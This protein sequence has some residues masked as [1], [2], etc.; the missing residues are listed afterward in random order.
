MRPRSVS[1]RGRSPSWGKRRRR[2]CRAAGIAPHREDGLGPVLQVQHP[3]RGDRSDHRRKRR[4]Q[5]D[6][7][8]ALP[9][10]GR[11]G[12]DLLAAQERIL[13]T[14]ARGI[15]GTPGLSPLERILAIF[16]LLE[17]S[18]CAPSFRSC[19]FVNGMAELGP[20]VHSPKVQETIAAYFAG[21]RKLV[22]S[23]VEPLA[24]D[25]PRTAV[26]QILTLIEGSIIM[27]QSM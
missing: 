1:I 11:S 5:N 22:A 19:P 26:I 9:V 2:P 23:R 8:Q 27:A 7:L 21:L 4:G 13:A 14:D 25:A 17:E 10:E 16:D 24:L 3:Y 15:D 12:R 18:F 20:E 6:V